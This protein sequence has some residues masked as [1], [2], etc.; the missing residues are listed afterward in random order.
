MGTTEELSVGNLAYGAAR[1]A[2]L[3][4]CAL[5]KFLVCVVQWVWSCL[6]EQ[7]DEGRMTSCSV[8]STTSPPSSEEDRTSPL[9]EDNQTEQPK[10]DGSEAL[11]DCPGACAPSS[12]C[13]KIL[14][15]TGRAS[16]TG[17]DGLK[18]KV[19]AIVD[20]HPE[21][22]QLFRRENG[23]L[24]E[25]EELQ[26]RSLEKTQCFFFETKISIVVVI[27]RKDYHGKKEIEM[28]DIVFNKGVKN[29]PTSIELYD[30]IGTLKKEGWKVHIRMV[31]FCGKE[32]AA[33]LY[34]ICRA[35]K[36]LRLISPP[37]KKLRNGSEASLLE[38]LE[39]FH[40]DG[41]NKRLS[42]AQRSES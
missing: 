41:W 36:S 11:S 26:N 5:M 15:A 7:L 27:K 1:L 3:A 22:R 29:M 6:M 40:Q 13:L 19:H 32:K 33:L 21:N 14:D 12:S 20:A 25:F 18:Q 30:L 34:A 42:S 4:A 10:N 28:H 31:S 35:L 17:T 8:G 9:P 39:R 24:F 16:I 37:Q 38:I 23:L 2:V